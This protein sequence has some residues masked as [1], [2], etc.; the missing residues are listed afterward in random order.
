MSTFL[1]TLGLDL[2]VLAAPMAGGAGTPALAVAAAR[3]GGLGFVAAG[4]QTPQALADEITTVAAAG[5]PFG[6][7]LFVPSPVPVDPGAFRRYAERLA[8]DAR[9]HGITLDPEPVEDDDQW[10]DKLDLLRQR[11]VPLIS[12]AFGIPAPA[13]L[14]A[15][16][17]TGALLLQ[18]VTNVDE[19]KAAAE[20]GVDALAVQGAAAGGHYGTFTP[21][22]PAA[23]VPLTDLLAA[24]RNAVDLPLVAA[25]GITTP[26]DVAAAVRAGADA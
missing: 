10:H 21:T 6:V 4:Y 26:E 11:R 20:A 9:R 13:D 12:L 5:V 22:R 25:G 15:L 7:N 3:A 16:R 2:P 1:R 14:A 24:I 8:A 18:T 17:A 19:A 23:A